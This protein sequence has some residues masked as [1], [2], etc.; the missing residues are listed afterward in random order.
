M[1]LW[2]HVPIQWCAAISSCHWSKVKSRV[3]FSQAS[4]HSPE[5]S[6]L[7]LCFQ[8][9]H[10]A[11]RNHGPAT[12]LARVGECSFDEVA[13]E[14]TPVADMTGLCLRFASMFSAWAHKG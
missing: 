4:V 9:D 14:S 12:S 7:R 6:S 10:A 13:V 2:C 8:R 1:W 3:E 5:P 11:L